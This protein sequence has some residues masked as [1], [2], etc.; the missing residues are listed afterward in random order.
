MTIP[1][2]SVHRYYEG[3]AQDYDREFY[4]EKSPYPT[5]RYRHDY[6]LQM[7]L[8]LDLPEDAAILDIGCGPGAMVVDLLRKRWQVT[9]IDIAANMITLAEERVRKANKPNQVHLAVGDIEHLTFADNSFDVII[10]S[11][12][13]EYLPTDDLWVKELG[14]VLRPGGVLIINVTNKFAIRKWTAPLI[15]PL[16]RSK[17]LFGAM[18]FFKSKVLR[19]GRLHH[20]PF[21]PRVHGPG[22]FDRFLVAH[23]Y[24][25]LDFRYFDFS[26]FVAPFDTL[27]GF[28]TIPI[29]RGMERYSHKNWWLSGTGYIVSAR[30]TGKS[31]RG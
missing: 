25:K 5:L 1:S 24:E 3:E 12:V 22:A 6:M 10:C 2:N 26:L 8:D 14:R 16:K 29:R 23:G 31:K 30:L 11:G 27:L 18:D 4:R 20:F 9:G 28:I 17:M 7:V 19:R 21:R 15:E 13:V